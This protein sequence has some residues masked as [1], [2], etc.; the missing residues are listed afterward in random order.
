[1]LFWCI[2]ETCAQV[3]HKGSQLLGLSKTTPWYYHFLSSQTQWS[4]EE[5]L[6]LLCYSDA[7]GKL[8]HRLYTRFLISWVS[9][10]VVWESDILTDR[11][12]RFASQYKWTLAKLCKTVHS[13]VHM[14]GCLNCTVQLTDTSIVNNLKRHF[15]LNCSHPHMLTLDVSTSISFEFP[16]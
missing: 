3:V 7:L 10:A 14:I 6:K 15:Q 2:R 5:T 13:S 4:E 8:V 9:K 16:I 1:M 12:I 11:L